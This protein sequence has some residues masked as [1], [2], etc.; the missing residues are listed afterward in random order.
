VSDLKVTKVKIENFKGIQS[1]ELNPG[2]TTFIRGKN[3]KGKSSLI[4]A[5]ELPFERGPKDNARLVREGAEFAQ[6]EIEF[7]DGVKVQAKTTAGKTETKV[8]HPKMG[9][10]KKPAFYLKQSLD[11]ASAD[12]LSFIQA[13]PKEQLGIF[14]RAFPKKIDRARLEEALGIP[15]DVRSTK[16]APS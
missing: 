9:E 10:L 11:L 14:L 2:Q 16:N 8:I 13:E 5:L 1:I 6:V 3:G 12:V 7:S 4:E 15:V